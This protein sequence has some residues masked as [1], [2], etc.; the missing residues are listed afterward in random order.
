MR[1]AV[2][3]FVGIFCILLSPLV[4]LGWVLVTAMHSHARIMCHPERRPATLA[5]VEGSYDN[6]KDLSTPRVPRS[7]QDDTIVSSYH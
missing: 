6:A 1:M 3:L 7:A 2:I 5:E 4:L